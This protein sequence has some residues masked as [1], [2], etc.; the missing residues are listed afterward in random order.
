MAE[1]QRVAT[2][3][4]SVA[5]EMAD[6]GSRGQS[7][8]LDFKLSQEGLKLLLGAVFLRTLRFSALSFHEWS[9]QLFI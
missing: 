8:F 5:A 3:Q 1:T 4:K 6:Q 2:A 7:W 9:G